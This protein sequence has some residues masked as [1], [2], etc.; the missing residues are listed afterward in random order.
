MSSKVYFI[1][2]ARSD[3]LQIINEKLKE[4]LDTKFLN[5]NGN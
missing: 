5:Q 4:L 2:L 1:P 3:N